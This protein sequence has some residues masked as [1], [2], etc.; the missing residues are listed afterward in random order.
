MKRFMLFL[1]LVLGSMYRSS[2]QD[3]NVIS[4]LSGP[5]YGVL[6][7]A[8]FPGTGGWSRGFTL[9]NQ[10]NTKRFFSFGTYGTHVNGISNIQYGYIGK[11][12]DETYMSFLPNGNVG[13]GTD[14]PKEKFS[15]N[16]KIRAKEIKVEAAPG[17]WPDYVFSSD[18]KPKTLIELE[19]FIKLNKHLPNIPSAQEAEE[20]GVDLGEMNKK[21]LQKIEELTLHLIEKDKQIQKLEIRMN[22]LE[23]KPNSL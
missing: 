18:Y 23:A 2:A 11:N 5:A 13:V 21:L 8:N 19:A 7:K 16:G 4:G 14:T 3:P 1:V 10:D 9:A 12:Y 15:V 17:T 6:I 22:K 20:K